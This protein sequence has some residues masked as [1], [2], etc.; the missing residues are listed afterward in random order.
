MVTAW[1][2]FR[3]LACK[4][5]AL[6]RIKCIAIMFAIEEPPKQSKRSSAFVIL[7]CT[8][9]VVTILPGIIMHIQ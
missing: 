5:V 1:A 2:H 3:W 6:D 7:A 9:D 4:V 8:M